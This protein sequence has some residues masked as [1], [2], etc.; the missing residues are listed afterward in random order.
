[1]HAKN[2]I[3]L[4]WYRP[5]KSDNDKETF[6]AL[7][8]LLSKLDAEG[9]EIY[10]MGDTN[11]DFKK[12]NEGPARQLNSIYNEFQFEQQIKEP[13][14]VASVVDEDGSSRVT[15]TL[16][17]HIATNRPSYI[18]SAEVLK[19]G[20]TDHYLPFIQRKI[21]AKR[22][23]NKRTKFIETRSLANYQKDLF[24][25]DLASI[26]WD[27]AFEAAAG[28]PNIMAS[29]F[30]DLFSS[31]LEVHAPLKRRKVS[32]NNTPWISPL[33]KNLM[34][35]RDQAKK[36]AEKDHNVWPRYKKL[37]NKVTSELRNSVQDYYHNLIEENSGNPKAMWKTINKVLNKCK[38]SA[39]LNSV[40]LNGRKYVR[41]DEIAEAFN[42]HFVTIGPKLA[43]K[44]EAPTDADPMAY[45]R[46]V[47]KDKRLPKFLFK[48]VEVSYV[49]QEINKLKTSK[50]PG[51]DKIPIK[52]LKDA[53]E[54]VSGPLTKIFNR[55]L[56]T[57]VF[58][59]L[60]KLARVAPIFKAGQKSELTNYR[61]ISVV[62]ILSR[63]LE[64]M[65][66]DQLFSHM[67]DCG[68][69]S[70]NQFAFRKLHNTQTS[71][72]NIT[73][74]WFRNINEQKTNL[75]VFLDLKKAFDTVDHDV[76]LSKL[77][78]YGVTDLAHGWFTS[79]LAGREQYCY[80]EGK[81][82]NKRLVQCGIPQGSCLG[83]LLF[84][85]YMNDF[86]KCLKKSKPNM[87]ADDTS[88]SYASNEINELFNEIKGELDLVSSWMRQNKL[89][90][91]AEKSEFMLIGHPKQLNKA[92]DFPDLEV[93]DQKLCRAQKTK[94]LGVIIDES[95][96]WEEQ[97]KTIKRKIKNG[98]GA[99][100][101]LKNILSQKQLATVYRALIE[102]HL[103]YCS[104]IWGCLSNTKLESLQRLQNRARRLIECAR[105]KDGWVCDWLDVR[106]LI[107]YDQL[108]TTYKIKNGLCPENL[109]NKFT[110]RS[111]ISKYNTR[112]IDDFEI[113]RLRLEYCKKSFGYQGASAWNEIP[114]Q[115]RD[116]ASLSS[117]KVR[118]R[119]LLR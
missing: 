60:W 84:I 112:K 52:I 41:P 39:P 58:P 29:S 42:E 67:K 118:L 99:M 57:G 32:S 101:K 98:L 66:H 11:C 4:C 24:L 27:A 54:I 56:D 7:T 19:I 80:V 73:E 23:L 55:S 21:N 49:K 110:P 62:S 31:I 72:M 8:N 88:I 50:S 28:D 33:I 87:Y 61:P 40:T 43:S 53:V 105:H 95:M 97:L 9:K 85:I 116:S 93:E 2:F 10:L 30:H 63:L 108:I 69:L 59:D 74:T 3:V 18:L 115:I 6:E 82:S 94:Y 44:I 12:P 35:E 25:S 34:R 46:N 102:S 107:K 83:P 47:V 78:A 51:P 113:P 109:K 13:T 111:N 117:F 14:R 17:D 70:D 75:S 77:S 86:E 16:I 104:V 22:L 65:A 76:L 114:K 45:V 15:K 37:R 91:N 5:P 20:M 68:L 90:L 92:K 100:F 79:Y 48:H 103:R 106:N 96:N 71:I 119:E 38:T 64:K 81:S 36:R 89:S 1:M 26:D